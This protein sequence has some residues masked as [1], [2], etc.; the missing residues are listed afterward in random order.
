MTPLHA[1]RVAVIGAGPAGCAAALELAAVGIDCLLFERGRPGKD[2]AC[3]DAYT[4]PAIA[5]LQAYGL[6]QSQLEALGGRSYSRVDVIPFGKRI[7][8]KEDAPG[9][10][11][12]VVPRALLDQWLR[13]LAASRVELRYGVTVTDLS[14]QADGWQLT[15]TPEL[16]G[17]AR[18]FDAVI[19]ATGSTNW[20]SRQ[21]QV[22]GAPVMGASISAYAPGVPPAGLDFYF[23]S[24]FA[25]GYAWVFPISADCVNLGICAL[26]AAGAKHLR[27]RALAFAKEFGQPGVSAWRGGGEAMWSGNGRAWHLAH[28]LVSCGDAAGL[29]DPLSGEGI[30]AA[31]LSG[32]AAGAAMA[33]YLNDKR[34]AEQL[35]AYSTWVAAFG[36]ARYTVNKARFFWKTWSGL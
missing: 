18:E 11:G 14:E 17:T 26:T 9:E 35:T 13:D 24:R 25:P 30:S 31:L 28:G 2:K 20:L 3:G 1:A 27:A 33:R 16:R 21:W 4:A 22:D 29:V 15:A 23:E 36:A 12:W 32:K 19:V 8:P 34:D 7:A 5:A 6:D 10:G